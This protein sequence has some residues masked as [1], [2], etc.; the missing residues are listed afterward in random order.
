MLL[1]V[2]ILGMLAGCALTAF[3]H[4][5][6]EMEKMLIEGFSLYFSIWIFLSGIF[7][8]ADAFSLMKTTVWTL[9]AE[10]LITAGIFSL[11]NRVLP[12]IVL[13]GKKLFPLAIILIAAAFLSGMAA[14]GL[15]STSQD[16]GLYQIRAMYYMAGEN[17][18]VIDFREYYEIENEYEKATYRT[19]IKDLAGFY[20]E[21]EYGNPDA[22]EM[23]GVLHGIA[24]FPALLALWG[25]MFGL[26]HM[27]GV[28]TFLFLLLIG[29]AWLLGNNLKYKTATNS[30]MCLLLAVCPILMWSS[31]NMLTEIVIAMLLSTFFELLTSNQKK[32]LAM[33]STLPVLALCFFHV[34]VSMLMPL[35]VLLYLLNFFYT[36][37]RRYLMSMVVTLVGYGMGYAMMVTRSRYYTISNLTVLFTRVDRYITLNEN[38]LPII[39]W[40]IVGIFTFLAILF[41]FTP[42]RRKV[43]HAFK[44]F[45]KSPKGTKTI[46]ILMIVLMVLVLA[47]M[48]LV[49]FKLPD[50]VRLV[51][52]SFI[53]LLLTTGFVCVPMAFAAIPVLFHQFSKSRNLVTIYLSMLYMIFLY[54]GIV[55]LFVNYYY[56]Y[57]RYLAPFVLLVVVAAGG[58][59]N[60]ISWKALVPVGIVCAGIVVYQTQLLY[61]ERDLTYGDFYEL[62]NVASCIG[63]NDAVLLFDEGYHIQRLMGMQLKALTGA[64]IYFLDQ[65]NLKFQIEQYTA[66]YDNLFLLNYD[67]G[68]FT[69]ESGEWRYVYKGNM[70]TS[71]YSTEV[72]EGLPYAKEAFQ[73]ES[74]IALMIYRGDY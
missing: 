66:M 40:V 45:R 65:V 70:S 23:E 37:D 44:E 34:T 64:D 29:N 36:R 35:F 30:M 51:N 62:E 33:F 22:R 61:Q 49:L 12:V 6:I 32:H 57:A 21:Q 71:I 60:R 43:H 16:E 58:L 47:D 52:A 19:G 24:T 25:K 11:G 20:L 17:K 14:E 27:G 1:V 69:E 50:G 55:W 2:W 8:W 59:M 3:A 7:I 10:I 56:Y 42:L 54:C 63:E 26:G 38:N 72:T 48:V 9:V 15:Y 68:I 18:N 28:L 46:G 4:K 73:M 31:K 41:A 5:K 13:P 39:I 74:P 67:T 53:G